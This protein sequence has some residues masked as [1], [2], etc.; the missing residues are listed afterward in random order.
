MSPEGRRARRVSRGVR[1]SPGCAAARSREGRSCPRT[2]CNCVLQR[3]GVEMVR[4]AGPD[5]ASEP[6]RRA[7]WHAACIG[8]VA[9][10]PRASRRGRRAMEVRVDGLASPA[11][12]G[13]WIRAR[14]GPRG[15]GPARARRG[16]DPARRAARDGG[17]PVRHR[18]RRDHPGL[19]AGRNAPALQLPGAG[20]H[21]PGVGALVGGERLLP[22][23]H[24]A[25]AARARS[26][27]LGAAHRAGRDRRRVRARVDRAH[28]RAA[29]SHR[30]RRARLG[31]RARAAPARPGRRRAGAREGV[32][33]SRAV[34]GP[35]C[36][37]PARRASVPS[38]R[39]A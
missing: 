22:R 12:A 38:A 11:L 27:L 15:P 32:R 1:L 10:G 8:S 21:P 24:R 7:R 34:R 30:A 6:L 19:S 13:R 9:A 14:P 23:R 35:R 26:R 29:R 25:L 33:A 3:I 20:D 2:H 17:D 37:R 36:R 5:P 16:A 28:R 4:S 39:C 31:V 18:S